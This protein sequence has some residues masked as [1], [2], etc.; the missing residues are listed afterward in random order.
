[1]LCLSN[2]I[3]VDFDR[4]QASQTTEPATG[5]PPTIKCCLH[6]PNRMFWLKIFSA[7]LIFQMNQKKHCKNKSQTHNELFQMFCTK[8]RKRKQTKIITGKSVFPNWHRPVLIQPKQQPLELVLFLASLC[9]W[10][11]LDFDAFVFLGGCKFRN[12][13]WNYEIEH[14]MNHTG[15]DSRAKGDTH[16]SSIRSV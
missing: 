7:K 6:S 15:D 16:I 4:L 10:Y 3:Y 8:I 2:N 12:P 13:T 1:M 11:F 14:K 5:S 9:V